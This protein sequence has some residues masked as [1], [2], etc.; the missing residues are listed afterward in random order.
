MGKGEFAD[1]RS[2]FTNLI[3]GGPDLRIRFQVSQEGK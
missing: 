3:L 1:T 2:K